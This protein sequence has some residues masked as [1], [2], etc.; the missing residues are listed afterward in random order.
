MIDSAAGAAA[1][2]ISRFASLFDGFVKG[3]VGDPRFRGIVAN[4]LTDGIHRNGDAEPGWFTTAYFHRP[5]ETSGEA[6]EAG[7]TV[8]RVVMVEGPLWMAGPRLDQILAN[9]DTTEVLL[10]M[11]RR[12]E[13]EPSVL[14][15][16]SHLLTVARRP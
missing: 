1:A 12:I 10:M 16:S 6:S 4:T 9:P 15:S 14:G 11:L 13:G 7:L 3:Y 5:E 2:T 8:E